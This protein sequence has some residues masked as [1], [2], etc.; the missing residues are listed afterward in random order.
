M[1][2]L[3]NNLAQI[4]PGVLF[5]GLDLGLDNLTVVVLDADGRR[6]D[7]FK[8]AHSRAGYQ[9]LHQRFQRLVTR[10]AARSVLVG[11]EPTNYYWK[12]V[13][14]FLNHHQQ[15]FRLVNP[16]TVNRHRDGDQ[17]DRAKDDW[18]DGQAIAELLRTGK[19]T[20]TQLRT[21]AYAELQ[22]GYATYWRLC[23]DR[24]RQLTLLTNSLRQVFPEM[25]QVFRD[26]TGR[27][28]Q[29]VLRSLPA[30]D[31]IRRLSW[32]EFLAQVRQAADCQ[33]LAVSRLRQ[34]HA[35]APHSIGLT[36]GLD[37]LCFDLR[38]SLASLNGL[39]R[40]IQALLT[41]LL[42]HFQALPEAP[43]LCSIEGLSPT[44]AMG[45]LAETGDL[46]GYA[47]GKS[48]IKLAGTSP[49][50]KQS[51]RVQR[52]RT[53]FSKHGRAR[54]R[55]VVYWATLQLL[56]RNQAIAYHYRRLQTRPRQPLTKMEAV[57]ACM[58]KLL[59]YVWSTGH[60][61]VTYDPTRWQILD[62]P[63]VD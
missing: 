36:E 60:H 44:L 26:L 47:S 10:Q 9:Y 32:V 40:Q 43:Y 49:T 63:A 30:A 39:D 3:A 59:W 37:S 57:G 45:V 61:R 17:L 1:S 58:N 14:T 51:G 4:K 42:Q 53:P 28:A 25:Q 55:W 18:R 24:G 22:V 13:A 5:A 2:T 38:T 62:A 27:T 31:H 29:A 6:V 15:P 33:R 56:S 8:S 21:G 54:L 12:Q 23:H 16:Y 35:L 46:T 50:P 19:F 11:M 41:Q 48:L 34:L 7:R 52:S 20:A